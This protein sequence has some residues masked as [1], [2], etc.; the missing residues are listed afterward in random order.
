MI[1]PN[2]AITM[3]DAE[4]LKPCVM[5][6][7]NPEFKILKKFHTGIDVKANNVFAVYRGR[8]AYIGYENSG[9]TVVIQTGSSFCVCYKRLKTVTVSLNDI[10]E[11]WYLIGSVDKYVHA[12]VYTKDISDWPVRIGTEDWYKADATSLIDG[13]LQDL[14]DYAYIEPYDTY[15]E[16]SIDATELDNMINNAG[17]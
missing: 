15:F 4:L 14:A 5:S 9:R 6:K 16:D 13:G 1:I 7:S 11:K 12:E 3:N 8:I 10:V 17:E 2:C